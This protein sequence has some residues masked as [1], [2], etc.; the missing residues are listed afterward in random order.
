MLYDRR[1]IRLREPDGPSHTGEDR[2]RM[3]AR[4]LSEPQTANWI[5][6]EAGW[7]HEPT[8]TKGKAALATAGTIDATLHANVID[9]RLGWHEQTASRQDVR[10]ELVNRL[11]RSHSL[12]TNRSHDAPV[13]EPD[14]F[15]V[16]ARHQLQ[17]ETR[18]Q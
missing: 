13:D 9:E 2:V 8:K 18:R 15:A 6:S 10:E 7:S 5:A 14:I 4:Q 1:R 16:K 11:S 12:A 3:V 17:F